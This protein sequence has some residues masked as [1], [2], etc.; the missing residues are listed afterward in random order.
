MWIATLGGLGN[1]PR[2]PGTWGST[3]GAA[4]WLLLRR[5]VPAGSVVAL[6]L[7][8]F[9]LGALCCTAA[10]RRLKRHD[11]PSVV[12]DEAWAMAGLLALLPWATW[13]W[14]RLLVAFLA[15]RCFDILKPVPLR[16]L[17]KLPA[18]WGIMAD[19]AGAAGYAFL[20]CWG[21]SRLLG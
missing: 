11:P 15:F 1:L 17:A 13:S 18:G 6:V 10:E 12:L 7:A 8:G 2:A 14:G 20:V 3:F 21:I 5:V 9:V 4:A 16:A 19:D